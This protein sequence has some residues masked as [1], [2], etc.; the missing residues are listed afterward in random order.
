MGDAT[1]EVDVFP[2]QVD[3]L[4]P[5]HCRLYGQPDDRR[6]EGGA[7]GGDDALELTFVGAAPLVGLVQRFAGCL[8]DISDA[9]RTRVVGLRLAH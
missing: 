8:F 6:E 5:A 7:G 3:D 1:L 2:A 4:A 9:P